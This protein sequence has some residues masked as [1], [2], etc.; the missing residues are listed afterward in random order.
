MDCLVREFFKILIFSSVIPVSV[1]IEI[2]LICFNTL[3]HCVKKTSVCDF[4]EDRGAASSG[5][6]SVHWK[7]GREQMNR[8][9]G[10]AQRR[11]LLLHQCQQ[12]AVQPSRSSSLAVVFG[13]EAGK[14][15]ISPFAQHVLWHVSTPVFAKVTEEVA[16]PQ[17]DRPL[18]TGLFIS[19]I[20][21]K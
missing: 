15:V 20:I 1:S 21:H 16:F 7:Q 11:A 13:I 9:R 10:W 12:W 5:Y 18:S 3:R 2:S 14:S 19:F 8:R 17:E 6:V 4:T